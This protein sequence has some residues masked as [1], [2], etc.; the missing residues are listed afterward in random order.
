MTDVVRRLARLRVPLG[1]AFAVLVFLLARPTP[2]FLVW[3][4]LVAAIG[5]AL[6]IWAA[7]HLNKSR[8]V[9][10]SGP[11]RWFAHPLYVG[12]SVMG[13]GL[14]IAAGSVAVALI[15]ALYLGTTI[16]AAIRS[17]EAFLREKF[18]SDYDTWRRG[19]ARPAGAQME[20]SR[21]FS[22]AQAIANREYRALAGVAIALLLLWIKASL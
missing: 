13:V 21:S 11:Y 10:S 19:G 18:G 15:V 22:M 20:A 8:E 1:F 14:A 16:G 2:A 5:E 9:T 3:G 12:S 17:E 7:G 6:R 4:G